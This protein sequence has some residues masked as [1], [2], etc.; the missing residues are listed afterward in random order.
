MLWSVVAGAIRILS[1]HS[2][3]FQATGCS[4]PCSHK[5]LPHVACRVKVIPFQRQ[6]VQ[7]KCTALVF[8]ELMTPVQKHWQVTR[9]LAGNFRGKERL[10]SHMPETHSVCSFGNIP[11]GEENVAVPET[12]VS[13]TSSWRIKSW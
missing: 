2:V 10:G 8:R 7:L 5:A 6:A 4:C 1:F 9:A 3:Y 11:L 13:H 12:F